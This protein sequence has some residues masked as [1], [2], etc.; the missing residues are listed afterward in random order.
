MFMGAKE[1][2]DRR[3]KS[4]TCL[5]LDRDRYRYQVFISDIAGH[6]IRSHD[7]SVDAV[8]LAAREWLA[9]FIRFPPGPEAIR[10]HY[11]AFQQE[12]PDISEALHIRVNEMTFSDL[13]NV[14]ASWL[15]EHPL[16]IQ[17]DDI[18]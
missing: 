13:I 3:Q 5:I 9:H 7:N 11:L 8:I 10:R 16:R 1:F 2:G 6:D 4:K 18:A 15:E 17:R 12:L 14:I